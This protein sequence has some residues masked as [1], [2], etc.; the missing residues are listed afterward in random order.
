VIIG[1]A[2]LALT[3]AVLAR[4]MPQAAGP[5]DYIRETQGE[6]VAF[7]ALWSYWISTAVT[8]AGLPIAVIGYFVAVFPTAAK[9]PAPVIAMVFMWTFVGVNL[10]GVKSGGRVQVVTSILKLVPLLL[11]LVF[12][13]AA[14]LTTP[15][16]YTP[17]VPANPVTLQLSMAAAAIAL[18]PM[19]GFESAAVAA[20]R[21]TNPG[22]TIPRATMIG[23]LLVAAIYVA[24]VGIGMLVVPQATLAVSDAPFVD[25]LDALL[26]PGNGRWLSLFVVISGLG[27]LNGWILLSGEMTRTLATRGLMPEIFGRSNRHGVPW[28]SLLLIGA[29]ATF[30]GLMNFSDTLVGAFTTITLIVSAANLPLYA[31]CSIALFY[32]L[33]RSPAGLSPALW[34]AGA[35]GIAFSAFAFFGLGWT[36]FLWALGLGVLGVPIYL[37]MRRLGTRRAAAGAT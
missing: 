4:K 7:A 16:T 35:G 14:I 27:C 30:V 17:N 15:E 34:L 21:V 19:L 9:I 12:G 3:F 23:T 11:V 32:M 24:I 6:T 2:C 26:G 29:V 22:K 10:L 37:W 20:D 36:P 28:A 1:C 8:V 25:M 5:F 18:Y 13:A 33:V 31:C